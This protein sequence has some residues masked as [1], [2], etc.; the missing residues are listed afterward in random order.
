MADE[1][2]DTAAPEPQLG[3]G[4]PANVDIHK[5]G[6]ADKAEADWGEPAPEGAAYSA[7]HT[8]RP[9]KT[10]AERGHGPKTRK[11]AKDQISRR[12]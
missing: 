1:D 3:Q 4:V 8:R 5:L 10:E 6:Q 7:N 12:M 9:V 11:A 2:R